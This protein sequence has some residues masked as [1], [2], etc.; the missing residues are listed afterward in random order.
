MFGFLSFFN[1]RP[2]KWCEAFVSMNSFSPQILYRLAMWRWMI[3][4]YWWLQNCWL[5]WEF[6]AHR[7][8]GPNKYSQ[9]R[10]QLPRVLRSFLCSC[11]LVCALLQDLNEKH[12]TARGVEW[13]TVLSRRGKTRILSPW[14]Q[15]ESFS[16]S[17]EQIEAAAF[18]VFQTQTL[19]DRTAVR[20]AEWS[21]LAPSTPEKHLRSFHHRKH[22]DPNN[23]SHHAQ[24]HV[25]GICLGW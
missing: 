9:K 11:G 3:Q 7:G 13:W 25:I 12:A 8:H 6:S 18:Q 21:L 16:L 22:W 24:E 17:T 15:S 10:Q 20:T 4:Y 23:I 19:V 5:H 1:H 2:E 14:P